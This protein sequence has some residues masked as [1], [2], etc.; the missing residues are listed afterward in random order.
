MKC[1]VCHYTLTLYFDTDSN[2]K[3]WVAR[4]WTL[5]QPENGWTHNACLME[6]HI[7]DISGVQ[8]DLM[9]VVNAL[10]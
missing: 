5:E 8:Q 2:Y 3:S 1:S 9:E 6:N 10:R 4:T 7:P